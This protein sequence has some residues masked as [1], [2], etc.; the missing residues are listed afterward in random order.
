MQQC[1]QCIEP[2]DV[3]LL[4]ANKT[5][6]PLPRLRRPRIPSTRIAAM[7]AARCSGPFRSAAND[8]TS[9]NRRVCS[10]SSR[11]LT[12]V[13]IRSQIVLLTSGSPCNSICI[14]P[15]QAVFPRIAHSPRA[16]LINHGRLAPFTCCT[17]G[18]TAAWPKL[19]TNRRAC[20]LISLSVASRSGS[21]DWETRFRAYLFDVA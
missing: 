17:S 4:G 1:N 7:I 10:F 6:K 21:N 5:D 19:E 14:M 11:S 8:S 20:S 16:A 18:R 3:W 2:N 13:A 12:V 9:V 15:C